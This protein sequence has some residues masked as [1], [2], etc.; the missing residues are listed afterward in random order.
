M[1]CGPCPSILPV[2]WIFLYIGVVIY[3]VWMLGRL[4]RAVEKIA[5]KVES[6]P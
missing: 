1:Q 3:F 2:V 6:S 5:R 4:V